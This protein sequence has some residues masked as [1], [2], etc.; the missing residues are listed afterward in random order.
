L[1]A[2]TPFDE[3]HDR[4]LYRTQTLHQELVVGN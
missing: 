3:K 4:T 1:H 2:A